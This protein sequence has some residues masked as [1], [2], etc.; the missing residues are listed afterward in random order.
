MARAKNKKN[1]KKRNYG[2]AVQLYHPDNQ[3][4]QNDSEEQ[5]SIHQIPPQ[6]APYAL[7]KSSQIPPAIRK[8]WKQRTDLFSYFDGSSPT[9]MLPL[10][11]EQSWFSVTPEAIAA[12]ISQRCQSKVIL[13]A[14]CG[15][16][17]NAIQFAFTSDHVIAIDIDP[18]KL[19]LAKHNAEVYNV[20][21]KITFLLGDWRD[22][23]NDW[24]LAKE[25]STQSGQLSDK[26]LGCE[27]WEIDV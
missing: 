10:L 13:D 4:E 26:W 27:R 6:L 20:H 9:G 8:Y 1:R 19:L 3:D 2:N 11:D 14:F 23:V 12:R 22:F 18:I 24:H 17:G 21:E 5:E 7:A 15:A 16:G 25:S